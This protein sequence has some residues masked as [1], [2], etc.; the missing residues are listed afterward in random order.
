MSLPPTWPS[1]LH[2][3]GIKVTDLASVRLGDRRR[4]PRFMQSKAGAFLEALIVSGLLWISI[5]LLMEYTSPIL[6]LISL[7]E[8]TGNLSTLLTAGEETSSVR[9]VTTT[10]WNMKEFNDAGLDGTR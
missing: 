2:G 4:R 8:L 7:S 6:L 1:L 10:L 9:T 5:F 3:P